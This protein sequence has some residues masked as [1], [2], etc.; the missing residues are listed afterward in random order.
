MTADELTATCR[1]LWLLD[2]EFQRYRALKAIAPKLTE[3]LMNDTLDRV[4]AIDE[5]SHLFL[6]LK[7]I[8]AGM[9]DAV[10]ERAYGIG[11]SADPE[12][13]LGVTASL[14]AHLPQRLLPNAMDDILDAQPGHARD[15]AQRALTDLTPRLTAEERRTALRRV[16]Q[17]RA[18]DW[19]AHLLIA[20][21]PGVSRT[22]RPRWC[23]EALTAIEKVDEDW[24]RAHLLTSLYPLLP[25]EVLA[26]AVSIA[27]TIGAPRWRVEALSAAI[28]HLP[29]G[30]RQS[31][32]E[33]IWESL[34]DLDDR[35]RGLA[36]ADLV[37]ELPPNRRP[38][39]YETMV[40]LARSVGES[41]R[42]WLLQ[43]CTSANGTALGSQLTIAVTEAARTIQDSRN[44][45]ETLAACAPHLR[46]V[47]AETPVTGWD[48]VAPPITTPRRSDVLADLASLAPVMDALGGARTVDDLSAVVVEVVRCWP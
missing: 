47:A 26:S 1:D 22:D 16:R 28:A 9:T 12:F 5:E 7:V 37:A 29:D 32:I 38:S 18:P 11:Q 14:A 34:G 20:L 42:A 40:T 36:L 41:D 19:R 39:I 35:D 33:A 4:L 27:H 48:A 44:R 43:R 31:V 13:R 23:Q 8:A 30:A 6:A 45:H 2:D 25:T 10:L 15:D 24:A 3:P 21:I 46:R 17:Q